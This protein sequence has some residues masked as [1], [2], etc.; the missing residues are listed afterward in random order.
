MKDTFTALCIMFIMHSNGGI[1]IESKA[2]KFRKWKESTLL[3]FEYVL[4]W[5]P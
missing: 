3:T 1:E 5:P 2:M 4:H